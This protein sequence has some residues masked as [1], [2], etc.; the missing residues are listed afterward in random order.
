[1][2]DR[3]LVTGASGGLGAEIAALRREPGKDILIQ[4]STRLTQSLLALD[5]V[6]ELNIPNRIELATSELTRLESGAFIVRYDVR[7]AR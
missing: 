5:L 3:I 6:D 4:N 7:H 2:A 1:M